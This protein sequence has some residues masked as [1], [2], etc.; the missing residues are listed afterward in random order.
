MTMSGTE[1]TDDMRAHLAPGH[2]HT[3][4]W[5]FDAL[6]GAGAVRSAANDS[7]CNTL[8]VNAWN[9]N[10][11][12]GKMI[13]ETSKKWIEAGRLLGKEPIAS[14]RCPHCGKANLKVEDIPQESKILESDSFSAV[15]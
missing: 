10:S 9:T 2:D 8:G 4:N 13:S 5:D 15:R 14:V 11:P 6:A 12:L 3:G 1:F 7:R